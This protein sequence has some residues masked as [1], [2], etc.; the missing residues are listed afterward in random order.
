MLKSAKV[1][2]RED[3]R[4]AGARLAATSDSAVLVRDGPRYGDG[5]STAI[6]DAPRGD[7]ALRRHGAP[8]DRTPEGPVAELQTLI[9]LDPR[10]FTRHCVGRWLQSSLKVRKVCLLQDP[11]QITTESVVSD[12]VRAVI[13]N[14]GPRGMSSGAS[15]EWLA[16]LMVRL[17]VF[18]AKSYHRRDGLA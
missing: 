10:A 7:G 9:Y 13:I 12:Q 6:E 2:R 8:V 1:E 15:M 14:T 11:E 5:D 16:P 18:M 17:S 4:F 3:A